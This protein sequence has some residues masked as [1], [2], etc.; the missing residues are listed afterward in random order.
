MILK[1]IYTVFLG[2]LL[3]TFVGVGIAAFYPEPKYPEFPPIFPRT[4]KTL[5][6]VED[7]TSSAVLRKQEEESYR[8]SQEFQKLSQ[9]YNKNVSIMSLVGAI[10][11]LLV[12]LTLVR[13]LTYIADGVLLGGVLTLLYS[14]V[15]GFGSQ[16]NMFRFFVVAI[17]L[18]I[19]LILGYIKFIK[20]SQSA[21]KKP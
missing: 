11:I 10:A 15:R 19:A 21:A 5:V 20:P 3:A 18:A 4:T 2:V 1:Y 17:G 7:S 8:I 14:I 16:D 12:S 6:E 9:E 13:N